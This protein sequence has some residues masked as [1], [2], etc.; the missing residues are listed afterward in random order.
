MWQDIHELPPDYEP[1]AWEELLLDAEAEFPRIGPA[2]VLA[3]TALEVLISQ[4]LDRLAA[5]SSLPAPLWQWINRR[6]EEPAVDQQY[7]ALLKFF[8][9]HSLKEE[10]RNCGTPTRT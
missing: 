5:Q 3:A 10:T 7:D 1:P 8:T 6:G 4:V 9:G 2:I